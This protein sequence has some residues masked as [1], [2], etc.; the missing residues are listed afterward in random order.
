[1]A[2]FKMLLSGSMPLFVSIATMSIFII[3]SANFEIF[4]E[5]P[6]E[7]RDCSGPPNKSK[8]FSS[9]LF[10]LS[11]KNSVASEKDLWAKS[12]RFDITVDKIF[13]RAATATF[14]TSASI[15]S[16]IAAWKSK[17]NK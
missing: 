16:R 12:C 10:I 15:L 2:P 11:P 8:A 17:T 6:I 7:S 14:C 5:L 4:F 9:W 1:M 3:F 13:A